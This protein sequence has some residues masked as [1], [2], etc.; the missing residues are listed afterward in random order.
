MAYS[1]INNLTHFTQ[2]SENT[3]D[4]NINIDEISELDP[5][6]ENPECNIQLHSHQQSLLY[7]CIQ[8]EN[9]SIY[10]S[11][12]TALKDK[13]HKNDKFMS[14]IGIIADRV[15]SGKSFVIL[16]IIKNNNITER[17]NKILMSSGYNN[18]VFSFNNDK[19]V[20]KLNMIV[21][22]HNLCSQWESYIIRFGGGF[23]YKIINKYKNLASFIDNKDNM[24][25]VD[26]LLVTAS[27]YNNIVTYIRENNIKLQRVIFDEVDSLNIPGCLSIDA[28]FL[29]FVTA[30]YGN[31]LYPRGFT[32]YDSSISKYVWCANGL[33]NSGFIKNIFLDLYSNIPREF[34]KVLVIKN[35]ESYIEESL[36]LPPLNTFNIKCKTP[37]MINILN[38][39]VDKNIIDSLNAGDIDAAI[40]CITPSNRSSEDNI[41]ILLVD[42]LNK[43]LTNYRLR[44]NMINEYLYDNEQDRDID[45]NNL[46]KKIEEL[47]NKIKLIT[48]R[49][50][51][52]NICCI[53][54]E[55]IENKTITKCCQNSFCFKCINIWLSRKPQCPMCKSNLNSNELFVVSASMIQDTPR[56]SEDDPNESFDK[57]KNVEILLKKRKTDAKILIFSSYDNT[58]TQ[59]IPILSKL[60]INYDYI[61]GN[62][63]QINSI[64]KKYK[65]GDLDVLLVNTRNYGSGMN[66]ENTSDIIMFHKFDTQLEN[67]VIGRAYR[68]GRMQSL[69]VYYLLHE[70][71]YK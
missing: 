46:I 63:N 58:F 30:S 12:F 38:G 40:L 8:Y 54:Y 5:K 57:F 70:N 24:D 36:N 67:Q 56:I 55:N 21:I 9:G 22:P 51:T 32:K 52:T 31:I 47:E 39:I 28:N 17:N 42:K 20:I 61:K 25:K 69:N 66:L 49:I 16:S 13:T 7:R 45:K 48:E 18:I 34:A 26:I 37:L 14:N 68:M 6:S 50:K 60:N 53:C 2:Y 19:K 43:Q 27:Y 4:F 11:D 10:L 33:K 15:G 71:E 35:S 44:L 64:I 65:T 1:V 59:L 62:G 41:V 23:N 3:Y 29:W